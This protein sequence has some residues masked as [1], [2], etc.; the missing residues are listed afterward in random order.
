MKGEPGDPG[1][2]GPPGPPGPTSIPGPRKAGV[3]G[4]DGQKV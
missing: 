2:R 3:P 1:A 4:T